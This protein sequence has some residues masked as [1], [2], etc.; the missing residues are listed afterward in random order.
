MRRGDV[1]YPMYRCYACGE[2]F[3]A[4][5][6]L[7]EEQVFDV[8]NGDMGAPIVKREEWHRPCAFLG[9]GW[10]KAMFIGFKKY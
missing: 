4:Q 5:M 3:R 10:G 2:V 8:D 6:E 9:G 7:T 1:F